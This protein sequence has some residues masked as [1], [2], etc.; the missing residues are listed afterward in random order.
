MKNI[1]ATLVITGLL[2]CCNSSD[3]TNNE[4]EESTTA[5]SML[6]DP[7]ENTNK[8]LKPIDSEEAL[9]ATSL[10]A[11]P[12]ESRS[13]C[14]VIGFNKAGE[15]VTYREGD[16]ELIVLTDDPNKEGFNAACYHKDL[17]PFM[18][19]GREL[20]AEGKSRDE[21]YEIRGEEMKSGKLTITPGLTLHIYHGPN[22]MYNPEINE[23]D[24]AKKRYV[25]YM[26]YATS[27]STG[28]PE[29]PLAPNHPWIMEPGTHR[30]HIMITPLP[31]NQE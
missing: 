15:F 1:L 30:A 22:E 8:E 25:V 23:V 11:A 4:K 6:E 18:A 16:N 9:I 20:R 5:K 28:L 3:S 31:N 29:S 21:I 19:R 14:K 10:L 12:A 26:P 24:G 27:E 2:I 13:N 17:E 7:S